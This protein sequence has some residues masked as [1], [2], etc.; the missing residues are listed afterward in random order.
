MMDDDDRLL[1]RMIVA[2]GGDHVLYRGLQEVVMHWIDQH[3]QYGCPPNDQGID[4]MRRTFAILSEIMCG[5]L[6]ETPIPSA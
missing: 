4:R 1:D 5:E 2:G 6:P 3:P